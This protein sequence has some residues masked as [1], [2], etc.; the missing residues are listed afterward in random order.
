MKK[1]KKLLAILLTTTMSLAALTG[2][3]KSPVES[4]TDSASQVTAEPTE[5]SKGEE[6]AI[7]FWHHYNAQSAENETLM[8]VL[9]PKFEEENPGIK[10]NAV[11][12][13]WANLHEKILISAQSDTLPDVARLDSAW[14]PEFEKMGILTALDEEMDDFAEVSGGLLESAMSTAKIGDHYYGLALNTNTKILFYNVQAFKDAGIEPPKTMDEF[15]DAAKKLSG[16]NENGQQ[17]WGY[18][19]PALAGWNLCPFIWSMGGS[20]TNEKQTAATGYIN[21]PQTVKAIETL[22]NLYKDGAITGWNSGDIPMTDGFGTGRYMMLLE[23]PWKVAEMA[24]AYPDFEYATAGMPAGEG[25]A[26]SVLGGEDI[27]MFNSANKEAAWKFM[28]FMTGE[29]AEEEMAKCGQIPVNK[30]ALE[31]ETVKAADYAPFLE[32]IKNAKSRPT[33]ACWSEMDSELSTAVTAV[34]NGEKTAQEAMDELADKFDA[35][36]A[37]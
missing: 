36:L 11:S 9:I 17:V 24:G 27:A 32:T 19:E 23:G 25:G 13:D 37:E 4:E 10:V 29:F 1:R 33:V 6:V 35:M 20:I 3:G 28:Q 22:A 5:T 8:N 2:C 15:V 14:V 26:V 21:S 30:E 31:S 34:M 7:N 16:T 12:H 18:N